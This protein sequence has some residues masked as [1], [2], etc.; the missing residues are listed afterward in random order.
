MSLKYLIGKKATVTEFDDDDDSGDRIEFGRW[1]G[2][3][4]DVFYAP[5]VKE[6]AA[7]Y[8]TLILDNGELFTWDISSDTQIKI[9]NGDLLTLRNGLR[10]FEIKDE[11][12]TGRE[13][14]LDL[15]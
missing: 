6:K 9:D 15:E 8:V 1:S 12:P 2:L 10:D 13:H 4:I 3:I 14:L 11:E 5:T 7:L